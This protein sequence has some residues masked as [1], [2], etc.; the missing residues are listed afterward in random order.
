MKLYDGRSLETWQQFARMDSCL[1]L[2]VPSDLRMLL[3]HISR[4]GAALQSIKDLTAGEKYPR[5]VDQD[6]VTHTRGVILDI[7]DSALTK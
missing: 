4:M 1:E 3:Q 5:W 2:M 6:Q 7:C